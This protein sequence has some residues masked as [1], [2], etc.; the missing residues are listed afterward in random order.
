MPRV[1]VIVA[2]FAAAELGKAAQEEAAA[3]EVCLCGP[4]ALCLCRL[5]P[6]LPQLVVTGCRFLDVLVEVHFSSLSINHVSCTVRQLSVEC[7]LA[8][9]CQDDRLVL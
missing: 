1:I 8:Q 5:S 7:V 3:A 4:I 2:C 6:S 9:F